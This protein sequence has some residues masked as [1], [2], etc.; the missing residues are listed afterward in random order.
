MN[1]FALLLCNYKSFEGLVVLST[2]LLLL[3]SASYLLHFILRDAQELPPTTHEG[4]S[5]LSNCA[6][7][8][9]PIC[10]MVKFFQAWY[11]D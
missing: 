2:F 5:Q 3:M 7:K 9:V 6:Q 11:F 4:N 10:V 1:R 8:H